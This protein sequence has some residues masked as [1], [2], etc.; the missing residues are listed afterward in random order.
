[1]N[2]STSTR[3]LPR[4][5]HKG[6]TKGFT[7]GSGYCLP[8]YP[9]DESMRI[10]GSVENFAVAALGNTHSQESIT[11]RVTFQYIPL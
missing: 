11:R 1:M 8:Y 10:R 2:Y 9:V 3:E 4:A 6:F 5:E 7:K